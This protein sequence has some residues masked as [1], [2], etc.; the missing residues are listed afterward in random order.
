VVLVA[1]DS[2]IAIAIVNVIQWPTGA[3][4]L[5]VHYQQATIESIDISVICSR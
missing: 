2:A 5:A 4:W 3:Y 1:S